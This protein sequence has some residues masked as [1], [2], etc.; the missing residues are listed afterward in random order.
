MQRSNKKNRNG[1][2]ALLP[3]GRVLSVQIS[4]CAIAGQHHAL[5]GDAALSIDL[6]LKMKG[7]KQKQVEMARPKKS[8]DKRKKERVEFRL[9]TVELNYLVHGAQ[10]AG[11]TVSDYLRMLALNSRIEH[12]IAP[13]ERAVLIRALGEINKIGSNVNQIAKAINT[14]LKKG[15]QINVPD[16]VIGYALSGVGNMA[17]AILKELT[18]DSPWAGQ[19]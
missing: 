8:E 16:E 10:K 5:Q 14:Q 12:K 6:S 15:Q 13:P 19:V 11:L 2:S 4:L 17:D 9:T 1:G 3:Q 18:H 7:K